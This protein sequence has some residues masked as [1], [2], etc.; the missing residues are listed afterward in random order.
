[1]PRRR[2][3]LLLAL[4]LL[5]GGAYLYGGSAVAQLGWT[6]GSE[7]GPRLRT[8]EADRG[9]ISA[10]VSATGTVNPVTSVIVGSQLSGQ[11]REINADFN[12]RVT[13]GQTLARLDTQTLEATRAAAAADLLSARAAIAVSQAQAERAAADANQSR[14]ALIAAQT[15]GARGHS[16]SVRSACAPPRLASAGGWAHHPTMGSRVASQLRR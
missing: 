6:N 7:A 5:A 10:V 9:A 3:A 15:H 4:P 11:I 14:A 13:A 8:A 16:M 12:T 2:L 1:M